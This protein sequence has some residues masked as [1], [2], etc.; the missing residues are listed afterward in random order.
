MK[1]FA[2][3]L[4]SYRPRPFT[5]AAALGLCFTAAC[6]GDSTGP[7]PTL[8]RTETFSGDLRTNGFEFEEYYFGLVSSP[9][10]ASGPG[11]AEVTWSFRTTKA[12][13][14]ED[15]TPVFGLS[16]GGLANDHPLGV[17]EA[18][19]GAPP[20]YGWQCSSIQT[21]STASGLSAT[22]HTQKGVAEAI[23]SPTR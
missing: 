2:P 3:R 17:V 22:R 14:G 15:R 9:Y 6:G 4:R 20:R 23:R 10:L 21:S 11:T 7:T 18:A 1:R 16:E 8:T 19:P 12:A 5:L 13:V